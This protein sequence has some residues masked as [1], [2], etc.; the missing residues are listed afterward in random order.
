M[1][2][3]RRAQNRGPYFPGGRGQGKLFP[4]P[5][6]T[7]EHR[8]P[9]GY[10]PERQQQARRVTGLYDEETAGEP[11]A[12]ARD[13]LA[14][15]TADLSQFIK[16]ARGNV[17]EQTKVRNLT[18]TDRED[19]PDYGIGGRMHGAAGFY[20]HPSRTVSVNRALSGKESEHVLLHEM[21]HAA[22]ATATERSGEEYWP[23]LPAE[24]GK[25]EARA[26]IFSYRHHVPTK[27]NPQ[28][29]RAE[30]YDS[31]AAYGYVGGQAQR[32]NKAY[33]D[34]HR[35]QGLMTPSRRQEMQRVRSEVAG[36]QADLPRMQS[37]DARLF[38]AYDYPDGGTP[39]YY[40]RDRSPELPRSLHSNRLDPEAM[41][42]EATGY[43]GRYDEPN[44]ISTR[45]VPTKEIIDNR[46]LTGRV[47]REQIH[48]ARGRALG[49]ERA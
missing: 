44:T 26:D 19:H 25:E 2:V 49:N 14:R 24:R 8:W 21:G 16:P 15:S 33:R 48:R 30:N 40:G 9:R 23:R 36:L 29:V 41:H 46:L 35:A 1:A 3:D 4:D 47:T 37:D 43:L 34:E 45:G 5:K 32:F 7:D 27:S 31:S 22:S 12:W 28:S 38:L 6:P 20:S 17:M 13:T 10:T 39:D 42:D 11:E 18:I